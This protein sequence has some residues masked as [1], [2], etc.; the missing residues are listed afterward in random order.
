MRS[1]IPFFSYLRKRSGSIN[2][3]NCFVFLVF[4]FRN[5]TKIQECHSK[6]TRVATSY[7]VVSVIKRFSR[8]FSLLSTLFMFTAL[9]ALLAVS[10]SSSVTMVSYRWTVRDRKMDAD[11]SYSLLT[12][13]RYP[14]ASQSRF[15]RMCDYGTPTFSSSLCFDI[16]LLWSNTRWRRV[17]DNVQLTYLFR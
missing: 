12:N 17:G 14:I 3:I 5:G 9:L 13:I 2:V 10:L 16:T 15:C 1:S 6:E 11:V 8:R 4:L 7:C